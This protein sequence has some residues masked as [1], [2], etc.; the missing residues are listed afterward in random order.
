MPLPTTI[1]SRVDPAAISKV[2]RLFNNSLH[3]VLTEL[4]QNARRAGATC[5]DLDLDVE[6]DGAT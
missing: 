6:R 4:F 3:D 1:H 5:V 2:T